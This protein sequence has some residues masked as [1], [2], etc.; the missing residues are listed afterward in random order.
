MKVIHSV[1]ELQHLLGSFDKEQIALVP[2]MGCL[3]EGHVSLIEKAKRL[4]DIVVVSIYIN[5]LQFGENEDLEE[6]PRPLAQDLKICKEQG[7]DFVFNP[8]N[9]YPEGGIQVGLHVNELSNRLCGSSRQGHFDGVV[10]VVNILFN[11]VQPQLAIFGEKDFQQLTIIQRMVSDLHMPVE[12]VG[13]ETVRETNGLAKS[14]RNTYLNSNERKQAAEISTALKRM[15][16]QAMKGDN[17]EGTIQTATKHLQQ[18]G[19]IPEYLEICHTHTLLPVSTLKNNKP[20]RAFIAVTIG[21]TRLIDNMPICIAQ[22]GS[23][24]TVEEDTICF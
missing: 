18:H 7:V 13:A 1:S 9:L 10:T 2:T 23:E 3:H 20:M 5:P 16:Q 12:V 14:S 19:I 22:K 6:Y 15:Q 8:N 24:I 11:I 4:A 17:L 21:K